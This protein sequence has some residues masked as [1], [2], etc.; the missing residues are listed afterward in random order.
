MTALVYSSL[1]NT[2]EQYVQA[3][4][5]IAINAKKSTVTWNRPTIPLGP[6]A[7]ER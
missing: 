5:K 6:H 7:W 2:Y 1:M 4:I 3:T